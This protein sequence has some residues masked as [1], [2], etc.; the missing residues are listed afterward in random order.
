[1]LNFELK[2]VHIILGL[3]AKL[4]LGNLL[5]EVPAS[6]IIQNVK[7]AALPESCV[8]QPSVFSL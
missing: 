5:S 8:P 7:T 1:V 6:R 3:V 4:Q 2:A